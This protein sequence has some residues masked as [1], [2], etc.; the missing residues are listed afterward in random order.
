MNI[1][2]TIKELENASAGRACDLAT[3]TEKAVRSPSK[4]TRHRACLQCVVLA[5]EMSR[6]SES[7]QTLRHLL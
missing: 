6:L 3:A 1:E 2:A 5:A 4:A 7:I